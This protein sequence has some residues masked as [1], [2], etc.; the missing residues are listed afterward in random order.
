MRCRTRLAQ[1]VG[2]VL[3]LLLSSAVLAANWPQ[4]EKRLQQWPGEKEVT[5]PAGVDPFDDPLYASV[6]DLLLEQGFAILPTAGEAKGGLVLNFRTTSRGQMLLLKRA[7]DGALLAM[8]KLETVTVP[9]MNPLTSGPITEPIVLRTAPRHSSAQLIVPTPAMTTASVLS[10]QHP[11]QPSVAGEVLFELNGAPL[12]VVVWSTADEGLDLYLMYDG[13]VQRMHSNGQ[14]LQLLERFT[15]PL[16]VSRALHLEIGDLNSDGQPELAAVWAE[17]VRGVADGTNSLLHS[18]VLT[19]SSPGIK[20]VSDDLG[21][22]IDLAAGQGRLQKR[23]EYRSF[24]PEVY[25][26]SMDNGSVA[27]SGQPIAIGTR[28]LFDQLE[29][30]D[31]QRALVWNDEQRLMLVATSAKTRIPGSTLLTD[32]GQYRGPVVSIPLE[33]PEYRSGFSANDQV[34]AREVSLARRMVRRQDDVF[35]LVR[36]RSEGM[37]LIGRAHG[38]DRLVA[39]SSVGNSLQASYPFAAIEAFIVDFGLYGAQVP[40]AAVLLNEKAD[41]SGRSYLRLQK[42]L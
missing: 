5:L 37:A 27:V 23:E 15:P 28:L 33:E 42:Q 10:V 8:E 4:L 17:D 31:S 6:V 24:A 16:S 40:Q 20:A 11:V 29:W 35:T 34:L 25:A 3:M 39:I 2:L 36:G 18:W 26:L 21:G 38:A 12:Q 13:Y 14:S 30:P 32:F 1:V 19:V 7:S 9:Q 22:Y 41:G